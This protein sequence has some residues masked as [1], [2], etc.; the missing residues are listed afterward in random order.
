MV[1]TSVGPATTEDEELLKGYGAEMLET[2]EDDSTAVGPGM[3]E[4]VELVI[5]N[6]AEV[7]D[8]GDGEIYT[9]ERTIVVETASEELELELDDEDV[10][11]M[12]E[13]DVTGFKE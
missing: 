11:G 13:L 3:T 7:L 12:E 8:T 1:P 10:D 9:V 2:A 5:E 6:G 4:D